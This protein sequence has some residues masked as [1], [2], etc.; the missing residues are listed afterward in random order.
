MVF[1]ATLQEALT[2]MDVDSLGFAAE[3]ERLA[4]GMS[5]LSPVYHLGIQ[6]E[7]GSPLVGGLSGPVTLRIPYG[8]Q[9]ASGTRANDAS[10]SAETSS[11]KV[12][13][14]NET[15]GAWEEVENYVVDEVA[16]EVVIFTDQPGN[17]AVVEA[18]VTY[19]IRLPL[20]LR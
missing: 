1:R 20:L 19:T 16:Q 8:P 7:N 6:D 3:G 4:E 17:Y 15:A 12:I 9:N 5:L 2:L 10:R 18:A 13:S 14:Y 11:I